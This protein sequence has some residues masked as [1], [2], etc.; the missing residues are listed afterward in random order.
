MK[1]V[2]QADLHQIQ[3]RRIIFFKN[4]K[5]KNEGNPQIMYSSGPKKHTMNLFLSSLS[6]FKHSNTFGIIW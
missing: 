6:F 2:L 4:L 1:I 3:R 5:N